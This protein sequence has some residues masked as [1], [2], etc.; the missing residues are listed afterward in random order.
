[1]QPLVGILLAN[2]GTPNN[3]NYISMRNYLAEFL[4]DKR[5]I[6]L[7]KL[8]WY[9]ILYGIIL[10][11]RPQ[12]SGANYKNIW[13]RSGPDTGS[14]LLYYTKQQAKKLEIF[15]H[16]K[17]KNKLN[18]KVSFGMR[19]GEPNLDKAVEELNQYGCENIIVLPL[20]PQYSATTTASIFDCCFKKF[21]KMRNVPAIKTIRSFS[22]N[23]KY[24]KALATSINQHLKT[25]D[26][27]PERILASFHGIPKSYCD[28]GDPYYKECKKTFNTLQNY[29][30]EE[31][32][33]LCFQSR[34]G[35]SEWLKPYTS[36]LVKT[37][38]Q[39]NITKIA[40]FN[41]GFLSDCLET[42]DEIERE[43]RD[44]FIHHGGKK[45]TH[46]PCLNDSSATINILGDICKKELNNF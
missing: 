35:K 9:P 31:K 38:P 3:Y 6:E 34:F 27:T 25:L 10:N 32:L 45:F 30:K 29:M 44:E 21:M 39:Q 12:K 26:F 16:E 37:L 14:P 7:N 15:L 1:M 5:I 2:L 46:I 42:I 11:I 33:V 18:I 24:I 28:K 20:F 17:Y 36:D 8:L 41:P 43:I 40:I 22:S 4:K 19:Y 23:P 13:N